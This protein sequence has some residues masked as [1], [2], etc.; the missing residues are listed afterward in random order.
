MDELH[1]ILEIMARLSEELRACADELAFE[2][3]KHYTHKGSSAQNVTPN[4]G[5]WSEIL[6]HSMD[7]KERLSVFEEYMRMQTWRLT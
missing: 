4:M 7:D 2:V 6:Y 5:T 1:D 3:A